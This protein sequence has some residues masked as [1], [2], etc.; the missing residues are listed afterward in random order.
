[1]R[2]LRSA[3]LAAVV[4]AAAL[5][6]V[7]LPAVA[8]PGAALGA[9]GAVVLLIV[10][11]LRRGA[12]AAGAGLAVLA[13]L[14]IT[15]AG[16]NVSAAQPQRALLAESDGRAVEAVVQV[17]SS[18]SIGD[19]G[20]LWFDAVTAELGP[21]G[22]LVAV[23]A[24][25]RVGIAPIAGADL[26]ATVRIM[27]QG[28]VTDPFERAG[29]V[30]FGSSAEV[31]RPAS[32]VFA[33]AAD[34]RAGFVARA[35]I[36]PEPGAGLLPGLAVGDTRAV[37][38][39][40]NDAMLASGLSHL[41]A[42]SG[43]NCAIVVAAVFWM[44][45]LLG[46]GRSMRVVVALVAL[47]AFV[48]L[49]TPEPS[50]VRASVMAALA[51]L[52][53]LLGRP[54]A[55]L[56]MLSVAVCGILLA[57]P[58]LAASP[59]F[60]LSAAATAALL[61]LS[62]PL[63]SGL[64]RWMPQPLALAI[65]V[66]LAAQVVC[67]PIIALF[68][69]QQ[70]LVG[71]VANL[72]AAP[73]APV[74]T[75]I[76]LL[77]CL[78]APVP[79]LADLLAATAWLPS[80]WIATTATVSAAVPGATFAVVAGPVAALLVTALSAAVAVALVRP[81]SRILHAGAALVLAVSVGLGGA[82]MLLTGP[83]A[84]LSTPEDWS[85]AACDVGQGD[86]F[87]I[88]S[89]D[90]TALIDTGPDPDALQDCLQQTATD[91][92]DLLV[93]THFDLDHAGGVAAVQGRVGTVLHGPGAEGQDVRALTSLRAGG[94][95]LMEGAA[96]VH[97]SLGGAR[98]RV[99]WPEPGSKAFPAGN[100]ASIVIEIAGGG[101]PRTLLLGDLSA[102][103]QR[104]L[105]SGGRLRGPYA[106][107]K[108]AHHGSRDQ[109]PGLYQ[110]TRPTVALIGVGEDNDYGHPRTETV[111][112]LDAVGARV[113]RTDEN[114]LTLLGGGADGI[115]VRTQRAPPDAADD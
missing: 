51:M 55:G 59:G 17:A 108:V 15:G 89:A 78:A 20:R 46:G 8:L 40:L 70:S 13:L 43:A 28:K 26:G 54:S 74:A 35:S 83:L 101:V 12:P 27:G 111:A 93:L 32:G 64:G 31:V 48:V 76:G 36:L 50:V 19:D 34:T 69:E 85:I 6:A 114:G 96:G 97:G 25:V 14:C 56:A 86:A 52:T 58:W 82:R 60:A 62:R 68:S 37:S 84:A 38:D 7:C 72:L 109:E 107:V 42:V 80:A 66:P 92:I 11:R 79:W 71:V 104:M 87:L 75:V 102:A 73:A 65:S 23:A 88:R 49:V 63:L 77:A 67:G 115:E 91:R 100:D 3:V 103:P 4:W 16:V 110:A 98:W 21:P 95:T 105:L 2:D 61:V 33:I 39:E 30:V 99:L 10:V 94:A 57:D 81:H 106:V 53:V 9:T 1:M 113:L 90:R 112:L 18:A 41:T 24:P 22:R 5:T 47:A 44:I 45:S 29:L